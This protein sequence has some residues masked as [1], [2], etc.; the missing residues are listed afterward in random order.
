M[1]NLLSNN[2]VNFKKFFSNT[3]YPG[4]LTHEGNFQL[5]RSMFFEFYMMMEV[6]ASESP[7]WLY[8]N[9]NLSLEEM[10]H[11]FLLIKRII[12]TVTKHLTGPMITN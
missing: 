7:F 3:D 2:H 6:S 9:N 1:D 10:P 12:E 4:A 5:V 8:S 11:L